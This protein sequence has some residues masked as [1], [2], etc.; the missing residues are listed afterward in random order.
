MQPV[1]PDAT[2]SRQAFEERASPFAHPCP[3]PHAAN[4]LVP[5]LLKQE[6]PVSVK[7]FRGRGVAST[8]ASVTFKA[9]ARGGSPTVFR[10]A[11]RQ[12][13]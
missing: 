11:N 12:A 1:T 2:S 8:W 9:A 6:A 7:S 3:S 10:L 13:R 5:P 4:A